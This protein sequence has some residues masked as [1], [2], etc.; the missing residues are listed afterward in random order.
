M[1]GSQ[2]VQQNNEKNRGEH[3]VVSISGWVLLI[4]VPDS[5]IF[6]SIWSGEFSRIKTSERD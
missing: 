3:G 2:S 6:F 1:H 5:V 4:V